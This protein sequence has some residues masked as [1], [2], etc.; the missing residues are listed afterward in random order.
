[1]SEKLF[2]QRR[3]NN[4]EPIVMRRKAGFRRAQITLRFAERPRLCYIGFR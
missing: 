3:K 2:A 1:M 4:G